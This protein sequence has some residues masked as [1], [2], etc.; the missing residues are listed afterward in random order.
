M[1]IET[2]SGN[3]IISPSILG[4][5]A[6]QQIPCYWRAVEFLSGNMAS[7][8][9]SVQQDGA[10]TEE[11]HPLEKLF[12][13]KANPQLTSK[14]CLKTWLYHGEHY[15]NGYLYVR[16]DAISADPTAFYNLMPEDVTPFKVIPP[17]GNLFDVE[18]F[19][20]HG[21]SQ[22]AFPYEDVLH[23]RPQLSH[24]GF[25][26]YSLP[27]MFLTTFTRANLLEHYQTKFLRKGSMIRGSVEF[28]QGTTKEQA[29][30]IM[31]QI[32]EFRASIGDKDIIGLFGGASLKNTTISPVDAQ[33][34]EQDASISKKI[35][36]ITGVPLVLL[37]TNES[38]FNA[39]AVEAAGQDVV[40][41]AFRPRLE[42]IE[43]ELSTKLLSEA[44]QDAGFFIHFDSGSLT[45]GD[46]A[47]ETATAAQAVAAGLATRNEGRSDIGLAPVEDPAADKLLVP[48]SV[49]TE[50][51]SQAESETHSQEKGQQEHYSALE[52]IMAEAIERV[53]RKTF[54]ALENSSKKPEPE[55]L[56]YQNMLAETQ[57]KYAVE[58]LQPVAMALLS[59][60]NR[61]LNLSAIGNAYGTEIRRRAGGQDPRTLTEIIEEQGKNAG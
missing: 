44:D 35:S 26:G 49:A 39:A 32:R 11:T 2:V 37:D 9:V 54:K 27:Q 3:S 57:S 45:R 52:P 16:R 41:F 6:P 4:S 58:A 60:A 5:F 22:R 33:L 19:Y 31:T 23:Y 13:R 20:Y 10:D 12:T 48:T 43:A 55:R 29:A 40:R 42:L 28:P 14:V 56:A 24:D 59:L 15:G 21:P 8:P 51:P 46:T 1:E 53:E 61:K 38:K 25:T 7:F 18:I 36:Q 47:V 34:M 17:D 30:E 50:S